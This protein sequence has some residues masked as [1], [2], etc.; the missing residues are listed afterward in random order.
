M[1]RF[2]ITIIA[3]VI[4]QSINAQGVM[5]GVVIDKD[6]HE[7]I[8][9]A[10]IT[11]DIKHKPLTVTDAEG[12]FSIPKSSYTRKI[13]VTYI[14]YKALIV[15][16]GAQTLD[17]KLQLEA[18]V[19]KLGEVVVTTARWLTRSLLPTSSVWPSA[20]WPPSVASR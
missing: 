14:G 1:Q 19:S 11:D 18:E 13:R 5:R 6:T 9:G 10:T 20:C 12:R 7:A 15:E 2:I 8:I 17:L 4:L 3:V 16:L